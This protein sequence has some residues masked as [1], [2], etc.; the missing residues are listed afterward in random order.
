MRNRNH[1]V[2]ALATY[3]GIEHPNRHFQWGL[4]LIARAADQDD[5]SPAIPLAVNGHLM[6]VERMPR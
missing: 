4:R 6:S 3:S 1:R 5:R 2:R